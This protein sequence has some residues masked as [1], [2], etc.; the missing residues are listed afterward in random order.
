[1]PDLLELRIQFER[2]LAASLGAASARIIVEDH[3]A[4]SK[5][6]AQ[7]LVASF[8]RM[9]RSL[10][11]SEEEIERGERLLAS[12]VQSVDDCIF[13]ADIDGR[14]VTMNPAGRR[15]LGYAEAEIAGRPVRELFASAGAPDA[16]GIAAA[17]D[18]GGGWRGQV[19]GCSGAGLRFPAYLALNPIFD[20]R[21]QRM[22]IVG[23]LRDVTEQ[24]ETERRLIQREK[25]ASLG[26]M[27]AGV[28]HEIRNPLGGIKMATNLLSSPELDSSPLSQ[29]MARSI[30]S[31]IAEIEGII[32]NLLDWT[33][34]TRLD[35]NE[36]PLVAILDPVM[37]VAAAD[38]RARGIAV[39][40]GRVDRE[41]VASVDGHRLRQVFTNVVTNALEAMDPRR[42]GG[43]VV[44][45]LFAVGG[46]AAIEIVDN[47][48]GIALEDRDRIFLPFF[49]TKPSGTGLGMSIVK[50]IVDL[51]GGDIAVESEPG[52]GTRVRLSLPALPA[53]TAGAAR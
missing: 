1:V 49:T 35:R 36:Y 33:R 43:R 20:A 47:G 5:E 8:Q 29:E 48:Q 50:K 27:A 9:Q 38:G 30:L 51:H 18:A 16:A 42:A 25:L 19:T 32:N 10:R 24:V 12:V 52:R 17:V 37:E 11:V 21:G 22:G 4:I 31:G 3:F 39:E 41:V 40:Y 46:R 23:V 28:A 6:E 15:L 26:E 53:A 34:D 13:T 7:Q 14:L 2:I 45:N 44:V